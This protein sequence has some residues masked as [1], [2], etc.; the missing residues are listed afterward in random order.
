MHDVVIMAISVFV[1][2]MIAFGIGYASRAIVSR[3]RHAR[4]HQRWGL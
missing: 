2:L 4:M 3:K 1:S